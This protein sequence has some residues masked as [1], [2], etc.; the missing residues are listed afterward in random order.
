MPANPDDISSANQSEGCQL[1]A[2]MATAEPAALA[3]MSTLHQLLQMAVDLGLADRLS[4]GERELQELSAACNIETDALLRLLR[5]MASLG[6]LAQTGPQRYALTPL[7]SMLE[8]EPRNGRRRFTW[9]APE[10]SGAA[11]DPLLQGLR[12]G[13]HAFHQR[14]GCSVFEWAQRPPARGQQ[15]RDR[16]AG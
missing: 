8:L 3:A 9:M 5:G 11:W 6:L 7:A 4:S 12:S 2:R 16:M 14:H 13:A 15:S 10:D 1:H